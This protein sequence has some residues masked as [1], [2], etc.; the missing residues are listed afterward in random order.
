MNRVTAFLSHARLYQEIHEE[1][2]VSRQRFAL[3]RIFSY[4]GAFVCAGVFLKMQL[5]IPD[6]GFLPYLILS[7]G[8]VM[9]LNYFSVNSVPRLGTAYLIMLISASILL[10]TVAY[11]C[12]G[13]RTSG[14]MYWGVI[15]LYAYMLLGKK[16]GQYFAGFVVVHLVYM[17]IISSYTDWTSF[18]LFKN[19]VGL[20]SQDFL[21][22]A[23]LS[24]FLIASQSSYMQG[25]DNVV[26]QG[27]KKSRDELENKN[28][29]LESKNNLLSS[30]TDKLEK[31]N[32]ELERFVAVA[33]HDLKAPLRAIGNLACMIEED[34]GDQFPPD[35]KKK[36]S[37]IISRVGRMDHLLNALLEYSRADSSHGEES[38]VDMQEIVNAVLFFTIKDERVQ[39]NVK[40]KLPVL[41][42]DKLKLS[43]IF[44]NL[45]ENA[46]RFS[47]KDKIRI[48][49][50]CE[51]DSMNYI[52][53]VKDN[54]PGIDKIY[55][56]KI[57]VL[58][59]T[60]QRRD[61]F[62]A[63]GVGL[64]ITKKIIEERGGKIWVESQLGEGSDFRFI[65][66]KQA[67]KSE[68]RSVA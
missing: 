58:F 2:V 63:M 27:L 42:N 21:T 47:D 62:E 57:F 11:S 22:N 39:V 12:G 28:M 34:I 31:T 3:F 33:S 43:R 36:L 17:F 32:H 55:H 18:D 30:Y 48:E 53:S 49:I 56:Q 41:Y 5:T 45:V 16:T 35:A 51:E 59:Q 23:I 40:G 37:S 44:G 7:L 20:I 14:T 13:I 60:L 9:L 52:F 24:L 4:T 64:A 10:H 19:E 15:V 1:D 26:I 38:F 67:G 61:E 50:S 68:T 54:G 8:I 29:E 25:G 66:P 46:I 65:L 6:A